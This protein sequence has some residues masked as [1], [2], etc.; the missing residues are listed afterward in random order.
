[1][2]FHVQAELNLICAVFSTVSQ[3]SLCATHPFCLFYYKIKRQLI[4]Q[5]LIRG[6]KPKISE[7]KQHTDFERDLLT[8]V[9]KS[10][11]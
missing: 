3:K 11:K 1:M 8:V 5:L 9:K 2:N 7:L 10:A 4:R 6:R